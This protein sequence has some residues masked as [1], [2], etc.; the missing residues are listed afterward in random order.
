MTSET[1]MRGAFEKW[2]SNHSH[3]NAAKIYP[4]ESV[5]IEEVKV[6]MKIAYLQATAASKSTVA[7]LILG[8]EQTQ[9]QLAK[10]AAKNMRLREAASTDAE[11][12]ALVE[13]LV[14]AL[15]TELQTIDAVYY[16]TPEQK[17]KM[18]RE[19]QKGSYKKMKKVL[20]LAEAKLKARE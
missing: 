14:R 11:W 16:G 18:K 7:R 13:K 12:R 4:P 2:H 6:S 5:G 10:V 8:L 19:Q 17:A 15:Q 20:A 3:H 9:T 1:E